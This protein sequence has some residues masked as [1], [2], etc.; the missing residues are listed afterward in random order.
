MQSTAFGLVYR[1]R[2]VKVCIFQVFAC[3]SHHHPGSAAGV[4]SRSHGTRKPV[5]T[6][7][8]CA[9]CEALAKAN[10]AE[11]AMRKLALKTLQRTCGRSSEV[12]FLSYEGLRWDTLVKAPVASHDCAGG[13]ASVAAPTSSSQWPP[14][15]HS[16]GWE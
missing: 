10:H 11:A 9:M 16:H 14:S 7:R 15:R 6:C 12:G 8:A 1:R 5:R 4:T 13:Y 2:L 3:A